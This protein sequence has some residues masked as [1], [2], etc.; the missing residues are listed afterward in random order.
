[1]VTL[2]KN[3][4]DGQTSGATIT[5]ANSATS[6]DPFTHV[7]AGTG[8]AWTYQTS[9]GIG[10]T[11]GAQLAVGSTSSYLRMAA[12][13]TDGRR[14]VL[15]RSFVWGG[16]SGAHSPILDI[17]T[18]ITET[19]S[20][21]SLFMLTS[22]QLQARVGNSTDIAASRSAVI[23]SGTYFAELAITTSSAPAANDGQIEYR[24]YESDGTTLVHSWSSAANQ[25]ITDSPPSH[26]R[27]SMMTTGGMDGYDRM[28]D[29]Q[30]LFTDNLT[31]WL[32]PY[33]GTR[34]LPAP[35][36][37]I[38]EQVRP[39]QPGEPDG[40]ITVTWPK[41]ADADVGGYELSV[42]PGHNATSDFV[43]K[44]IIAQPASGSTVTGV[45]WGL[46]SGA[47]TVAVRSLPI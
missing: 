40:H 39:T 9:A 2:L 3:N 22:G 21:G 42:A 36:V 12:S 32:G 8:A 33:A 46:H 13:G 23:T 10:G 34:V 38:I 24:V 25:A 1:M 41:L 44:Q 37:T 16:S 27:F 20:L 14:C 11:V 4:F 31:S 45:A 30:A 7:V 26:A 43:V 5:T 6:G 18:E 15:R 35:D 19:A 47:H 28:D 29:V 17:R